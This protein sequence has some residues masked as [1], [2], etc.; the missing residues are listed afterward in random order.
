MSF[1]E[2]R[3]GTF[4]IIYLSGNGIAQF[5]RKTR[6]LT[7]FSFAPG[8]LR[9]FPLTGVSSILEDRTGTLWMGTVSDG[10]LRFDRR[11]NRFMRYRSDAT[12]PESLPEDRVIALL[13]DREGMIWVGFGATQP[14]Y[15]SNVRPSFTALPFD[16]RN[17]ANLGERL[18]NGIYVDTDGLLWIG[19]TGALNRFNPVTG[20][21]DHFAIGGNG[22]AA[23]VL[24]I[25]EDRSGT[26]WAGTSGQGLARIDRRTGQFKLY[27][28]MDGDPSS[29]SNDTIPR[30]FLDRDGRLWAATTDG[31][32]QVDAATGRFSV[33]RHS[34]QPHAAN[35]LSIAQGRDGAL[36]LGTFTAG[37]L[38]F[39]P[40]THTFKVLERQPK[41]PD[42]R[43]NVIYVARSGKVWV[44]TQN[45]LSE[46]DA[47]SGTLTNFSTKNGLAS[48]LVSCILEDAAGDLWIGTSN[49]LSR[50]DPRTKAFTN[51]SRTDGL[52]GLDLTGW[53]ACSQSPSGEM[54][55]GGFAGA[56]S[57]HPDD[58]ADSVYVPPV[59]LTGFDL[60]GSPVSL[61][62]GSPL[63]QAIGFTNALRL[64][65]NQNSFSF[66]F[67]ALS[68]RSPTTN[69]YRYRL[70]GLDTHWREVGSDQ[71]LAAYT[72]LPPGKYVLRLQGA[73]IRGPWGEPGRIV[74]IT[75][76]PP[77]WATWW[78]RVAALTAVLLWLWSAYRS[79]LRRISREFDIR[80]TE[81]V[82]ERTRIARELHDSLLQG[83][84]G[85]M[86]RLQGV[87]DLLPA[88]PCDAAADLD[89]AMEQG[90]ET[91]T[92]AREAVQDLRS[93]SL[94]GGDLELALRAFS[95]E[96]ESL[97]SGT[98]FKVVVE[99][100]RRELA[101]LV[102]DEI[103][104]IAREALRNAARHADASNIE[105]ELEFGNSAFCLRIRDDGNGI[106]REVLAHGIRDTFGG[107]PGIRGRAEELGGKL[108]VWSERK[109]GT[110]V[111]L[112]VPARI[113]Y[114]V[115]RG[116]RSSDVQEVTGP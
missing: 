49:G 60:F 64:S 114:G 87:H 67:S 38:R 97:S 93:A 115:R 65:H 85:L 101:P 46:L 31:L 6:L 29:L 92:D 68:F 62:P 25:V 16:R 105:A 58:I 14:S 32:N 104:R 4:W 66:E 112:V 21:Y 96:L 26:L 52:P 107:L 95:E 36:L 78:F 109:A 43:T 44:G 94:V 54:F 8:D 10:L 77:W 48:N 103:Y 59:V 34:T 51:Y 5:N 9:N 91:I 69:R 7:R 11:H 3:A 79:Q 1:Y 116:N 102:R 28:H 99:G 53:S 80:L 19:T 39:D 98:S 110:E 57:F 22:V 45:G 42:N 81:R 37:L 108:S 40:V 13:E 75:I 90:G 33:Y 70:E 82:R 56:V 41:L 76:L 83:F 106:D 15:F 47:A 17:P 71:R 23:D 89:T 12:N 2:D 72:T 73:T 84:Q 35:Y 100:N 86:F 111:E 113:A 50:L 20:Q 30:L 27:R 24:S 61:E 88:R 63:P 74:R 55:F 18:V